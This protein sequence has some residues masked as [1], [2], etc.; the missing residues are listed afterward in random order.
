[1]KLS[2]L[3]Q[4][5]KAVENPPVY[6]IHCETV[7]PSP[8]ASCWLGCRRK[9]ASKNQLKKGM[10]DNETNFISLERLLLMKARIS[11]RH[12]REDCRKDG[13]TCFNCAI[14]KKEWDKMKARVEEIVKAGRQNVGETN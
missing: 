9:K 12:F 14:C 11:L 13:G 6:C 3:M 10:T 4:E 1:M 2:Q 7:Y 8:P 5:N